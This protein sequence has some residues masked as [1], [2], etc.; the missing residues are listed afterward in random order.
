MIRVF[1]LLVFLFSESVFSQH[2]C[3]YIDEKKRLNIY[4]IINSVINYDDDISEIVNT[5]TD[6][7]GGFPNF[8]LQRV[9]GYGNCAAVTD[10]N[11]LRYILYDRDFLLYQAK[12]SQTN[13]W[14]VV[15]ILAHEIGHHINGHNRIVLGDAERRENELEADYFAGFI[16]NKLGGRKEDI[17]KILELTNF[18]LFT[19]TTTHPSKYDRIKFANE[20]FDKSD[21]KVTQ[22]KSEIVNALVVGSNRIAK[23]VQ[24][25]N[26]FR[27]KNIINRSSIKGKAFTHIDKYSNPS[28]WYVT[29]YS[30]VYKSESDCFIYKS[31]TEEY[32]YRRAPNPEFALMAIDYAKGKSYASFDLNGES[33]FIYLIN[34]TNKKVLRRTKKLFKTNSKLKNTSDKLFPEKV[35]TNKDKTK[36]LFLTEPSSGY[37]YQYLVTYID[38]VGYRKVYDCLPQNEKKKYIDPNRIIK[39]LDEIK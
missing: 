13:Y 5:I 31:W 29:S 34:S 12:T 24:G 10:E 15:F 2:L 14:A 22:N 6:E 19:Y 36:L 1:Y 37:D 32:D 30:D 33:A 3:S 35:W 16:F 23:N 25:N 8:V 20:G 11:G 27:N 7:Y 21:I 18:D 28:N 17:A 26:N 38:L 39:M 9:E 4:E